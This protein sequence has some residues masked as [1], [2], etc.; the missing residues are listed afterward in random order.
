MQFANTSTGLL[1][2]KSGTVSMKFSA[3][4]FKSPTLRHIFFCSAMSSLCCTPVLAQSLLPIVDS[5]DIKQQTQYIEQAPEGNDLPTPEP[6]LQT[7]VVLDKS[8][9][10]TLSSI[11][12]EATRSQQNIDLSQDSKTQGIS[13]KLEQFGYDLFNSSPTTFSLASNVPIPNNYAAGPGDTLLIQLY[14]KKNVEYRLVIQRDGQLLIPEVGPINT[15]GLNLKEL[16]ELIKTE[17]QQRFIGANAVITVADVRSIQV[18]ITGEANTPG[19]YTVNGL[20]TLLNAVLSSGGIK[21]SGTLRDI[22]LKRNGKTIEHFDLYDL[23]LKGDTRHDVRLVQGDVLFVP[24]IGKTIGIGGEVQRPGIYELKQETSA[25]EIINLAGGLQPT[26][27]VEHSHIERISAQGY[28]TLVDFHVKGTGKFNTEMA[29]NTSLKDGDILRI[30]PIL[31]VVRDVVQLSGNVRRPGVVQFSKGMRVS[32]LIK[33]TAV[34]LPNTEMSFALLKRENTDTTKISI[35]YVDLERALSS[36]RSNFD[37]EFQT[38]DE[39][40]IFE[41]SFNREAVTK[42]LVRQLQKQTAPGH[43]ASTVELI[44]NVRFPGEFPLQEKATLANVIQMAG[45]TLPGTDTGYVVFSRQINSSSKLNIFSV[46]HSASRLSSSMLSNPTVLPGDRIF[47]F[48]PDSNRVDMLSQDLDQLVAQSDQQNLAQVVYI[49]GP[50]HN[51]G[52]YPLE[53]DMPVQTLIK[54]AGGLKQDALNFEAE[55]TRFFLDGTQTRKR[56]HEIVNLNLPNVDAPVVLGPYDQIRIKPKPGFNNDITVTVSGAVN[57]PGTFRMSEGERLCNLVIRFGGITQRGY[58]AG[59]IFTRE[60]TRIKQQEGLDRIQSE[61]DD[62]LVQIHLSP[63]AN[64][65][66]KMPAGEQKHQIL[67]TI[68]QLK[69]AKAIGRMV[70]DLESAMSCQNPESIVLEDGDSIFIPELAKDVTVMGQVYVPTSHRYVAGKGSRDYID[71]S[72]GH[73]VLGRINHAYVVQANGEV[74]SMRR[75][76]FKHAK[77]IPVTPGATIL[78]PI[79]VDRM[80]GHEKAQSWTKSIFQLAVAAASL[81]VVGIF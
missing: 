15:L 71:L 69:K 28:R 12:E 65:T 70:I 72:G 67:K 1:I 79:D 20:S 11:E 24:P 41:R 68:Q 39:L 51:P 55:L 22:Q 64:N 75:K 38:R 48:G 13:D 76:F 31:D 80:N 27:S 26:A 7:A 4:T 81:N 34:L 73:T 47:I 60:T 58:A 35:I 49:S 6:V 54:A 3:S 52:R 5:L 16:R 50:V 42:E 59:A 29:L 44:G 61:L 23:L 63:S 37:T 36:P 78:V 57:F 10:N 77:S 43:L 14:G 21:R 18:L 9:T 40:I 33:D 19:R 74:H 32:D 56:H 62:L 46:D 53:L 2:T 30:Q 17:F 45:G 25:K 8:A 66:E